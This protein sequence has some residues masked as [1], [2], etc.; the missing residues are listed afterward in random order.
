MPRRRAIAAAVA[1]A[2]AALLGAFAWHRS[3]LSRSGDVRLE[4]ASL[5]DVRAAFN[6]RPGEP[7]VVALLSPD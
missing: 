3:E 1:I 5:D 2:L 6:A 4:S 7:R